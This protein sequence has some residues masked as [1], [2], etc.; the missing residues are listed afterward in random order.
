[1]DNVYPVI[2]S[3]GDSTRLFPLDKVLTPLLGEKGRSL[4]QQMFDLLTQD[5][6][7]MDRFYMVTAPRILET[8]RAQLPKETHPHLLM[9]PC[10]RSTFPALLWA[11]AHI[12][13]ENPKA[14]VAMFA[15]DAVTRDTEKFRSTIRTAIRAAQNSRSIVTLGTQPDQNPTTWTQY[16]AIKI[17]E[18]GLDVCPIIRF[19]EKPSEAEAKDLIR[20]GNTYWNAGC[21][22]FTIPAMEEALG[23]YQTTMHETYREMVRAIEA[24]NEEEAK[25]IFHT[26]PSE[27]DKSGRRVDNSI[28]HALMEKLGE[29]GPIKGIMVEANFS[30][31][32]TGNWADVRQIM[33]A[34]ENNNIIRGIVHSSQTTHSV[35]VAEEGQKIIAQGLDG[36]VVAISSS[37]HVLVTLEKSAREVKQAVKMAKETLDK[38]KSGNQVIRSGDTTNTHVINQGPGVVV[39]HDV[40]NKH[41]SVK[42]NTVEIGITLF[43]G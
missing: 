38:S 14:T 27:L 29:D 18:S 21:F 11:V 8:V 23:L 1:M 26:F 25:E 35:L 3:G 7:S 30:W 31:I 2:I 39:V 34:D 41:I 15:A 32:D 12:R 28:D 36:F 42:N 6:L 5:F 4:M 43:Y 16:G 20:Q 13:K 10:K 24:G 9:D 19:D 33:T 37:G 22:I 17:R 40:S